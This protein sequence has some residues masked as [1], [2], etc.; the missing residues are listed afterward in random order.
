MSDLKPLDLEG[1]RPAARIRGGRWHPACGLDDC[2]RPEDLP[3]LGHFDYASALDEARLI[4]EGRIHGP[5][6]PVMPHA[7]CPECLGAIG[8]H[9]TTCSRLDLDLFH[10][11]WNGPPSPPLHVIEIWR[12]REGEPWTKIQPPP[13]PEQKSTAGRVRAALSAVGETLKTMTRRNHD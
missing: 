6:E 1:H 9:R 12:K 3:G 13:E 7:H 8:T 4:L 2:I 10:V 5:A 11:T